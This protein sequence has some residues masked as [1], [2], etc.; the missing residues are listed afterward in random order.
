MLLALS[1]STYIH[2][3][4]VWDVWI[5]TSWHK[6]IEI[7]EDRVLIVSMFYQVDLCTSKFRALTWLM[8]GMCGI[9]ALVVPLLH[10]GGP[11]RKQ[12][13]QA[14]WSKVLSNSLACPVSVLASRLPAQLPFITFFNQ[15]CKM[16]LFLT[17]LILVTCVS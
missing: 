12:S 7:W 13:E 16:S 8:V 1:I 3:Y 11:L 17:I 5:L 14:M 4:V 10:T 6:S 2:I 15:W 9:S